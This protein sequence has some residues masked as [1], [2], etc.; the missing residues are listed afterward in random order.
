MQSLTDASW[1]LD[2]VQ[3]GGGGVLR[4]CPF[5]LAPKTPEIPH[6]F[7]ACFTF[8]KTEHCSNKIK[9]EDD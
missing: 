2:E 7:S 9:I 6:V 8:F 4:Q 5:E 3:F 1:M